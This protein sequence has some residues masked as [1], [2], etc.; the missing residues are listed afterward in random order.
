M[1]PIP[2]PKHPLQYRALGLVKGTLQSAGGYAQATLI[3]ADGAE[4]PV[5]PGRF[6]LLSKFNHCIETGNTYW[7]YVHPQ[8]RLSGE[9]GYGIIK[10]ATDVDAESEEG[11]LSVAEDTESGFNLRGTVAARG[12]TL[13]VTVQRQPSGT[14][15]FPPLSVPVQ[16]FLPGLEAGEFWDLWAESDGQ[17]LVL[18][19]GQRVD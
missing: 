11:F 7:F 16:G 5:T 18:V 6:E 19:D 4:H 14:K 9:M 17:E 15:T 10:I 8:P 2:S 13:I 1:L 12:D 3:T